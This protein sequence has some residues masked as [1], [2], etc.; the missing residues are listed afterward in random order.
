MSRPVV[1]VLVA[2]GLAALLV[3]L[4]G[5]WVVFG[6]NTQS[7]S[8]ARS[9]KIPPGSSFSAVTDSL[10]SAG[11]LAS[12]ATFEWMGRATGWG[13]QVKAGHYRIESGASNYDL[14]STLRR[15]LQSP[16]RVTVPPGTRP[17]VMA[18]LTGTVMNF[19]R[20]EMEA[21]LKDPELAEELGTDT[22]S[23]FAYMLPESYDFYWLTSAETVVR[24]IK[25]YFDTYYDEQLAEAASD[26]DL[27]KDELLTLAS[28]I[29]WETHV[30]GERAR[31]A[32]VYLNRLRIG[33]PLQADPTVQYAVMRDEGQKRRLLFADYEIDDP[34][35][36]YRFQGLP[37]APIT[38][39]SRASLEAAA[40]AEDHDY[41]Y[42]VATGDGG[43]I[44]SRT[45]QEHA[46]AANR[47]RQLMRERR[48][49]Q[50]SAPQNAE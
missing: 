30:E 11:I 40:R 25:G 2:L 29:E 4:T 6:P 5:A 26:R 14:L 38:N 23:L 37:P 46:R 35:N 28:I 17:E 39:P 22:V 50:N 8:A 48:Q 19:D 34:F 31:V 9:V 13:G 24:R 18:A 15:G 44:F 12:T 3:A 41:L 20:E 47:Y 21:A 16:I 1:L 43:H 7:Y 33:M 32:G 27:S 36:T 42:F 45:F 49:Q 10:E